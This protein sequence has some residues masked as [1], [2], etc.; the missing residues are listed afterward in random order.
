MKIMK[1]ALAA[2]IALALMMTAVGCSTPKDAIKVGN[3]EISTGEYLAYLY[4]S[5]V[6]SG[7]DTSN[8]KEDAAWDV[9]VPYENNSVFEKDEET[10]EA[11]DAAATTDAGLKL[12]DAII[13]SAKDQI[14]Y[15][16][17]LQTI[18]DENGITVSEEK[19]K[20]LDDDVNSLL[21]YFGVTYDD[22]LSMGISEES[23][24]KAFVRISY[25]QDDV[26]MGL[27][28]TDGKTPTKAAD[29]DKYFADNYVAYKIISKDL[30]DESGNPLSDEDI[31][32]MKAELEAYRNVFYATGD[33]DK[34]VEANK[35]ANTANENN[36]VLGLEGLDKETYNVDY[37]GEPVENVTANNA[38]DILVKDTAEDAENDLLTKVRGVDAGTVD[39]VEYTEDSAK[40]MA[41]VYRY[42]INKVEV[43]DSNLT[44]TA[45]AAETVEPTYKSLRE[46]AE[47]A[48]IT[49]LHE[50]DF[51]K[52]A[53]KKL[54]EL[55]KSASFNER[56]VKMCS[57]KKFFK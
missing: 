53:Q 19:M 22:L 56:T 18:A 33:F 5:A 4:I 26:F 13:Q 36:E 32:T 23:F 49:A 37:D 42:D 39:I 25:L 31:E 15:C 51:N 46:S 38:S 55:T 57:P 47:D 52:L 41:L 29:I 50:D 48:I 44:V 20:D 8:L 28:G 2:V 11:S 9:T 10:S 54:D 27:Y 21:S 16:A 12:E 45:D 43:A 7:A 35:A 3:I 17:T 34:A 14:I 40:K 24:K 6:T 1:R 30:V